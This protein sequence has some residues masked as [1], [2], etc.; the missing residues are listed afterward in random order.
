MVFGSGFW[1]AYPGTDL[2]EIDLHYVLMQLLQLRKDMQAVIDAQAITFADPINWNITS[3]YPANQVVLDSN[4]DGYISR[5]AVP[6]GIPLSN[7]NYW[8]Q[9][10][11]FND[12]ADRIRESIAVNA[13]TSATAPEALTAGQLVWWQ[14]DIYRVLTDM[15]AGTAFITG[16]NVERFTVDE[17]FDLYADQIRDLQAADIELQEADTELQQNI[18][19][20]AQARQDADTQLQENIDAEA[21]ARQDADDALEEELQG[22]IASVV[23]VED[24]DNPFVRM[25]LHRYADSDIYHFS[26]K[27]KTVKVIAPNGNTAAPRPNTVPLIKW[28]AEHDPD[29][30]INGGFRQATYFDG[31]YYYD[32]DDVSGAASVFLGLKPDSV[33]MAS[34]DDGIA[35]VHNAGYDNIVASIDPVIINGQPWDHSLYNDPTHEQNYDKTATR[36]C[37]TVDNGY[38][39]VFAIAGRTPFNKGMTFREQETF[40]LGLGYQNIYSLDG[41]GSVGVCAGTIP[42]IPIQDWTDTAYGRDNLVNFIEFTI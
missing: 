41:G 9:I 5:Q 4:G 15:A 28:A 10:F 33:Y 18:D 29:F 23:S 34:K 7:T 27:P 16:T 3:Q 32:P 17:K 2:H 31:V 25:K 26:F 38:W 11:S 30:V 42:M 14:G 19:D 8:T 20:E 6:A 36:L 35:V 13:G 40:F 21:Q 37:F 12:I 39:E 24:E 1:N 22:A